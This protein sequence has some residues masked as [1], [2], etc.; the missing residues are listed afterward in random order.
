MKRV[1]NLFSQIVSR[2][3]LLR[4]FVKA[5]RGKGLRKERIDY[6]EHLEDNLTMLAVG[7][8]DLTYPVGDYRRFLIFDPK[9]R[10]ICAASFSERVLHHAIMNV[11]SPYFERFLIADS[12]ANRKGKG[13]IKAVER[14]RSHADRYRWF[15]KCD[16]RKYFDSIPHILLYDKLQ[17]KFKDPHLLKWFERLIRAYEKAS[18]I[19]LPIGNLT[20]QYFANLYLD[21]IDRIHAPYVRY[22]DDFV[23]WSNDKQA[24]LDIRERVSTC[25]HDVLG[26]TLKQTPYINR[27][28]CGMDFLGYRVFPSEVRLAR[29]SVRR[30]ISRVREIIKTYGDERTAQQR[31]TSMT[32]FVVQAETYEWRSKKLKAMYQ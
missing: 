23:F 3:N 15:L 32:A 5:S 11:C 9:E 31:L 25:L 4:A 27:T 13:L 28:R 17:R 12:Y 21:A 16:I 8:N 19:G 1:G 29:N 2:E 14:A 24:L 26:L 20:S 18:G 30:Y 10:E 6:A 22:M 7:L